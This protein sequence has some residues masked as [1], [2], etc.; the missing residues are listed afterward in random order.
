[1]DDIFNF[2]FNTRSGFAVLFIGGIVVFALIA[3]ILEHRTHQ[4]YVDRGPK[5]SDE[6]E[7]FWS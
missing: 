2:L 1:M 5:N 7:G 6:E 4:M 3:A